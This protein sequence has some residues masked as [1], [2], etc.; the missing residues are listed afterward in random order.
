[1]DWLAG[2]RSE[3]ACDRILDA[4]ADLFAERGVEAVGMNDI[5]KAAGCSRATLYRYYPS[6]DALHTAYVHRHAHAVNR[7]LAHQI[8]G[9]DDPRERL[10]TALT[11]ALALV[12]ENPALAA[13]F[14]RTAIGAEAAE[15][16]DVVQAMTAGF[17]LTVDPADPGAAGR[18]ARWLVRV[19][20]SFL[21]VPGRDA[22]DE[23][24]ML[25]EF[26]IPRIASTT[27]RPEERPTS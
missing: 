15:G 12:R 2:K 10:L 25:E 1:V 14:T 16:S 11:G 13:W 26:V 22:A 24:A 9:I 18:Q 19:L 6:R 27:R 7:Q 23:R 20:T 5:A 21:T 3:A 8:A 4:A 17:L